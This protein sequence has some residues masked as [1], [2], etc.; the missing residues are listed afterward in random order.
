MIGRAVIGEGIRSGRDTMAQN[1][2]V[3]VAMRSEI[4]DGNTCPNCIRLDGYTTQV[5]SENFAK[6]SPPR[7]CF[8]GNN[9]RG[10]WVYI[11]KDETPQPE[12]TKQQPN[13]EEVAFSECPTQLTTPQTE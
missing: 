10:I 9:C 4:L 8:G 3:S 1:P 11:K 6:Y 2:D 13:V 5:N 12:V 7:W